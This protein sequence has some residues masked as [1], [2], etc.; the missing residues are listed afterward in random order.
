MQD[1]T[2]LA[3]RNSFSP[4]WQLRREGHDV[5]CEIIVGPSGFE[6]RFLIDG[7][8]LYSYTFAQPDEVISWA[9]RK[10]LQYRRQGWTAA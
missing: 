6:G 9:G 5:A 8:F 2:E 7:R 3:P 1:Y 4:L 10:E